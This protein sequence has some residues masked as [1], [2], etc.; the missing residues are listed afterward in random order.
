MLII[1]LDRAGVALPGD[2]ALR[3]AIRRSYQLDHLPTE[4]EVPRIAEP[5]RPYRSL[6][7][8]YLFQ[9][10]L[11]DPATPAAGPAGALAAQ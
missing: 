7:T 8:A 11:D 5:W 1:A 10:A 9:V 6:A 3:K 2:L 4:Q